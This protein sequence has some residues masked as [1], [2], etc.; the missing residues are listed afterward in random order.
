M[1]VRVVQSFFV[2]IYENGGVFL[3]DEMDAVDSDTLPFVN[4]ALANGGIF[5]PQHYGRPEVKSPRLRHHGGCEYVRDGK[6]HRLRRAW[7]SG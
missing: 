5:L 2:D 4:Q 1:S 7:A 3:F 6:Q